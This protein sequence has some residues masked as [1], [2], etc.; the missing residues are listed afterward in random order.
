MS[1]RLIFVALLLLPVA[2]MAQTS[3]DEKM[4]SGTA[5]WDI[6]IAVKYDILTVKE[7][8]KDGTL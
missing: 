5:K 6:R 2:T 8:G 1:C 7:I 3:L 4:E